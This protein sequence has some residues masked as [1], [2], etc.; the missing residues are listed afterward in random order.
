[1]STETVDL[2]HEVHHLIFAAP[3]AV[4]RDLRNA[5]HAYRVSDITRQLASEAGREL[6]AE[7]IVFEPGA[8]STTFYPKSLA[9]LVV[10]HLAKS[11]ESGSV[12]EHLTR[13]QK[14]DF[15]CLLDVE[16]PILNLLHVDVGIPIQ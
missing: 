13:E 3:D 12:P 15:G 9:E 16:H 11:F 14:R 4:E 1:M 2:L 10:D 7:A 8:V 5:W 6:Y